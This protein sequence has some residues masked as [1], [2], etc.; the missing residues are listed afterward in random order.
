M[1]L[2]GIALKVLVGLSRFNAFISASLL[3]LGGFTF[4]PR[5]GLPDLNLLDAVRKSPCMSITCEES[6]CVHRLMAF[7]H[8]RVPC[9]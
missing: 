5:L 9:S 7:G 1:T 3:L 6:L 4:Q 8:V 2:V